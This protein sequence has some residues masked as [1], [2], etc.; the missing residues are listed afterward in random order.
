[1][2]RIRALAGSRVGVASVAAV[3]AAVVVSGVGWASIP[4]GGGFIHGCYKTAGTNHK[5]SIIDGAVTASCPHGFTSLNWPTG[6]LQLTTNGT[7]SADYTFVDPAGVTS[8]AVEVWGG[9]GGGGGGGA[10]TELADGGQGGTGGEGSYAR[11]LISLTPGSTYD[12]TVG[13]GGNGGG[14]GSVNYL[15]GGG[16]NPAAN[17]GN[18][19]TSN[20]STLVYS[21]GGTGGGAGGPADSAEYGTNGNPGLGGGATLGTGATGIS[22]Q[23]GST[24][25]SSQPEGLVGAGSIG[26]TGGFP[27]SPSAP[28]QPG[29]P[30]S[31]GLVIVN[32]GPTT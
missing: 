7:T 23:T 22:E 28:G 16:I 25:S 6:E 30:G 10:G 26:G 21:G 24:G 29:N 17:G 8:A 13:G 1:M 9:G 27:S 11:A 3:L 2:S 32:F 15:G 19:A 20:F 14:P 5:L 18:G 12:I 31:P 4:D